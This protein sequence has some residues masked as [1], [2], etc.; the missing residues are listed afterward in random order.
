MT[1]GTSD[2]EFREFVVGCH[3]RLVQ[4]A[5]VLTGDHARAEDLVQTALVRTHRYWRR[6]EAHEAYT[7]KIIV[8]LHNS[9]WRRWKRSGEILTDRPPE[10]AGRGAALDSGVD[11]ALWTALHSLPPRTRAV[12]VL[13]HLQ[14][15]SVAEV[16]DALGCSEGTVK[17]L[18]SRGL[19]KLREALT[20]IQP[21]DNGRQT[22][23]A[24]SAA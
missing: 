17:S 13:R 3:H 2:A 5:Y 11:E 4:T 15:M 20:P 9:W 18:N 8:N 12:V 19:A 1:E 10:P 21:P 23:A 6:V 7:R 16:A 24:R 22:T 14:D